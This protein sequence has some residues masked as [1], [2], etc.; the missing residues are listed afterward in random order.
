VLCDAVHVQRLHAPPFRSSSFVPAA[1]RSPAPSPHARARPQCARW[2]KRRRRQAV[3]VEE[4]E[5]EEKEKEEE[6][7]EVYSQSG[8][9][10]RTS[11]GP[12]A[13]AAA[14]MIDD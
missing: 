9:L 8:L 5:E 7:E 13:L 11:F 6:E 1:L 12:G 3:V 2:Y 4:E 10:E 14:M